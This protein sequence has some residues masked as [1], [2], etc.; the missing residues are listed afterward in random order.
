MP[1][2]P[3]ASARTTSR[4]SASSRRDTVY[5]T[6]APSS[7]QAS[8]KAI[9]TESARRVLAARGTPSLTAAILAAEPVAGAAHGVQQ[10]FR[11]TRVDLL[12]Q[13]AD[14]HV[15]DVGLRIEVVVPHRLEQHRAGDHA[16]G[17]AHQ[18]FEQAELARQQFD[19][20]A[21][22]LRFAGEQVEFEVGHAQLGRLA[23]AGLAAA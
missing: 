1:T 12:P 14:V 3:D 19:A 16:F 15:D 13:A 4:V 20:L 18:V 8:R 23:A 21:A 17:L 22:A 5:C 2:R 7:T 6:A 9:A 10:G 11:K